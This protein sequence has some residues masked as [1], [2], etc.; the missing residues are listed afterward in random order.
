MVKREWTR[1]RKIGKGSAHPTS[2]LP[3]DCF[4]RDYRAVAVNGKH[5]IYRENAKAV[6]ASAVDLLAKPGSSL[7]Q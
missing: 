5:L 3:T 7:L 2:I 1:R 6:Y 4:T